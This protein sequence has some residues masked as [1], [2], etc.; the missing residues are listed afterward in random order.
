MIALYII[1]F[2]VSVIN[3]I[4][5]AMKG[6]RQDLYQLLTASFICLAC[7]GYLAMAA[8]ANSVDKAILAND[9]SY[10]G[11]S[12][13]M[14]CAVLITAD[15]CSI[16]IHKGIIL[17]MFLYALVV[18]AFVYSVGYTD[19]YYVTE[20]IR[21]KEFLGV[22]YMEQEYG[23][24]HPLYLLQIVGSFVAMIAMLAYT[25]LQKRRVSYKIVSSLIIIVALVV[26]VYLI[27]VIV[28]YPVELLPVAYNFCMVGFIFISRRM[29]MFD[30][31]KTL[32]HTMEKR[33][34][35]GYIAF[36]KKK[37][38]VGCNA[39][40]ESLFGCIREAQYDRPLKWVGD[41]LHDGLLKRVLD[42]EGTAP[43]ETI[44]DLG[45]KIYKL[46]IRPIVN[47]YNRQVGYLGEMIDVTDEQNYLRMVEDF[48][49]ELQERVD[50][51]VRTI[52][53]VRDS[54]VLGMAVMVES[55]DNSTGGHVK[56]TSEVVKLFA[57]QLAES[58]AFNLNDKYL[59]NLVKAAP[60]HDIGKIA[61]DDAI[62]RK[63]G[64]YTSE[65][66]ECMKK[67]AIE[68]AR[69]V[70]QIMGGN[71]DEEFVRVAVNM[72]HFHHEK[73]DGTGYPHN[74]SNTGI[75]LEARIMALADVFDALVS[76]R[77]YKEAMDYDGA[78][79]IIEQSS[80]AHF[81]PALVEHFLAIRPQLEELYNY[82]KKHDMD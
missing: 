15:L 21:V 17:G 16:K 74:L 58:R 31:S 76:K 79:K 40:A 71:E 51:Q 46:S 28:K 54:V 73:W 44:V 5:I 12:M 13:T 20:S 9:I 27:E 60:L 72:A 45:E 11:G 68:G 26:S 59:R 49:D 64:R 81:E 56:R 52:E 18:L 66:Y 43:D 10:T 25:F 42:Y 30:M 53:G 8:C 77:C 39:V 57:R 33:E 41:P 2:V 35:Y 34:S 37:N 82:Y 36:D 19:L 4:V 38:F 75:P 50:K 70:R 48:N 80:G 47:N 65:E 32:T 61:V 1:C 24:L 14:L 7:A 23:I 78:F 55:R 67:H 69:L 22:Y 6:K 63:P 62:L 3:L 29:D